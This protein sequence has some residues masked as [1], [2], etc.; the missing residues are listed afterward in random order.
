MEYDDTGR[1]LEKQLTQVIAN[2]LIPFLGK[3]QS[4]NIQTEQLRESRGKPEGSYPDCRESA[5]VASSLAFWFR[6]A[7]GPLT[8]GW[9]Y[10]HP[11]FSVAP[12]G[13]IV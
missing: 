8:G 7:R 12:L 3:Y 13:M 6:G 9:N 2:Y 5:V 1:V 10:L 11:E 4:H